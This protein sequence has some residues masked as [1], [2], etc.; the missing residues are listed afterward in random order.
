MFSLGNSSKKSNRNSYQAQSPPQKQYY[1]AEYLQYPQQQQ[2]IQPPPPPPAPTLQEQFVPQEQYQNVLKNFRI[3][4]AQVEDQRNQI[5]LQ[6]SQ[7][8]SLKGLIAQLEGDP[9]QGSGLKVAGN[10]GG[11]ST[12][13]FSIKNS[14]SNLSSALNRFAASLVLTR[15][16][17]LPALRAAILTDNLGS[18][19]LHPDTSPLRLQSL[20]RHAV[21]EVISSGIVNVLLVTDSAEANE[22]LTRIH[23]NLFTRDPIVASVW[24][25]Q[26]FSASVESFSAPLQMQTLAEHMPSLLPIMLSLNPPSPSSSTSPLPEPTI[27]PQLE[28][29][30]QQAWL[31]GRMLHASR[32]SSGSSA[33]AF[34]RAFMPDLGSGLDPL[35][36]ELVKRCLL[37]ERGEYEVVG[38][39]LFPGLVKIGKDPQKGEEIQTVVRRAQVICGCALVPQPSTNALL[40]AQAQARS[41]AS[42]SSRSP[43]SSPPPPP[44]PSLRPQSHPSPVPITLPPVLPLSVQHRSTAA[45]QDE[46]Q[47]DGNDSVGSPPLFQ[48]RRVSGSPAGSGGSPGREGSGLVVGEEVDYGFPPSFGGGEGRG[49]G[50]RRVGDLERERE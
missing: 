43:A 18:S 32:P 48:Q 42:S 10:K 36:I 23:D 50:M 16:D 2:I 33:N 22:Q 30:L 3:A 41:D 45:Q 11:S 34:Y 9:N 35:Q 26:T 29:I 24:R 20:I 15:R 25:R 12:D 4:H 6:E 44:P 49:L 19:E 47:G 31:F 39:C 38:A 1:Q 8:G 27:P 17:L 14:A 37:S 5:E 7:I 21:S 28:D 13:D 40:A 46:K